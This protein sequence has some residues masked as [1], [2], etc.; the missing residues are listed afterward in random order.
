MLSNEIKFNNI[1]DYMAYLFGFD[2][3]SITHKSNGC[4]NIDAEI[5]KVET[6]I[7]SYKLFISLL[8]EIDKREKDYKSLTLLKKLLKKYKNDFDK[9]ID[10]RKIE[11]ERLFKKYNPTINVSYSGEFGKIYNRV[12]LLVG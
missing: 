4:I 2:A 3:F 5:N 8:D 7:N 10:D 11:L 6:V 12:K 9:I 1:D